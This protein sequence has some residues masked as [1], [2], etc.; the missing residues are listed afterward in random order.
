M[1]T[2]QKET[3][4]MWHENQTLLNQNINYAVLTYKVSD[5]NCEYILKFASLEF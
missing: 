3:S 1:I 5:T 2:I 4:Y